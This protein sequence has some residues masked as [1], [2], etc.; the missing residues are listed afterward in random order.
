M[1]SSSTGVE[2]SSTGVESS[3]EK[4]FCALKGP[5]YIPAPDISG[6]KVPSWIE[7]KGKGRDQPASEFIKVIL[8]FNLFKPEEPILTLCLHTRDGNYGPVDDRV[9]DGMHYDHWGFWKGLSLPCLK[10][11]SKLKS[12]T[13]YEMNSEFYTMAMFRSQWRMKVKGY[14]PYGEKQAAEVLE[15]AQISLSPSSI[16]GMHSLEKQ[17]MTTMIRD[18]A[19]CQKLIHLALKEIATKEHPYVGVFPE[20]LDIET[21]G[22]PESVTT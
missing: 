21:L 17:T 12:A 7:D 3:S 18:E 19:R 8:E 4:K 10:C 6:R 11:Q 14:L 22:A 1:A 13:K 5:V 15:M 20:D 2:S 9:P 16:A